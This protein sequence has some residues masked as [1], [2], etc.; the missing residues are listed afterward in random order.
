MA[1]KEPIG[2][3]TVNGVHV[4]LYEGES[5]ED[6]VNRAIAKHNED[7]KESDIAKAK[8]QSD[9]LNGKQS[10]EQK[11][12]ELQKK[13][14]E[15][16]SFLQKGL[17]QQEIDMLKAN[18]KGTKEEWRE[19]INKQREAEQKQ[20][21]EA[22]KVKKAAEEKAKHDK[23]EAI[24]KNLE[25][26]LKTQPKD[27]VEQYKIIQKTNPMN[28]DYHTGIRKPSDIKTWEEVLKSKDDQF[29]WGDFSRKDAEKAMQTGKITIYSSYPIKNGVFV[30]TSKA[31]SQEYAG[32]KGGRLYSKTIPLSKVA[33][34]SGDEGQFADLDDKEK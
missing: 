10:N 19:H 28:D 24:R 9:K 4:P 18:W 32:G 21:E 6:A 7:K 1:D 34:I 26:E 20:K 5:K 31:Q 15:T 3:I 23:E 14:D 33:W 22:Y 12:A 16:Q 2:W 30:S 17:I 27:K 11:I 8:E 25:H 13:K 29:T